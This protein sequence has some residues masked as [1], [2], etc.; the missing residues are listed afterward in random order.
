[1][2]ALEAKPPP[3]APFSQ[4]SG[5]DHQAARGRSWTQPR[6]SYLISQSATVSRKWDTQQWY[7]HQH[8]SVK[9][10][11]LNY[12]AVTQ[13]L[14]A[15]VALLHCCQ[16]I[17][18]EAGK[19]AET[20]ADCCFSWWKN[21]SLAGNL[22]ISY[23]CVFVSEA[24]PLFYCTNRLPLSG[25]GKK[26]EEGAIETERQCETERNKGRKREQERGAHGEM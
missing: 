16:Y 20:I 6:A 19:L 10:R 12:H 9:S 14:A 26:M 22:H 5:A 25:A 11:Q 8:S 17:S 3:P 23:K 2:R 13:R 1:M 4:I 7:C 21:F 24:A 15:G 18:I